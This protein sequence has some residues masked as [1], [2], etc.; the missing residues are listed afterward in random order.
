MAV[1]NPMINHPQVIT[2]F[3]GELVD[4]YHPQISGSFMALNPTVLTI[5]YHSSTSPYI[6]IMVSND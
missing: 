5:Q 6:K 4:V 3:L 2:I 1:V